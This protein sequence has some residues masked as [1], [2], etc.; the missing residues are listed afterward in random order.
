MIENARLKQ[1]SYYGETDVWVHKAMEKYIAGKQVIII[2]STIPWYESMALFYKC[3]TPCTIVEYSP[4]NC[5]RDD[6][7]YILVGEEKKYDVVISIS[8]T[9]HDGLGRYGDPI[10]PNA[11]LES[12]DR[13]SKMLNPGGILLLAVPVG[14]DKLVW[15][16][17]R[18]YGSIRLPLLLKGWTVEE[19]YPLQK[20]WVNDPRVS[21][22]T[23][24]SGGFQPLF[25]LKKN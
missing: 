2:G 16:V 12:M 17:H 9:E 4:R 13:F 15:N 18:I 1:C 8:S 20:D 14:E 7:N 19:V 25:I 6:L 10:N 5:N 23:G 11:D 3:Q 24:I 21:R 22:D